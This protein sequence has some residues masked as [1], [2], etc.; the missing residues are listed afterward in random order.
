MGTIVRELRHCDAHDE[1]TS[2]CADCRTLAARDLEEHMGRRPGTLETADA[3][4]VQAIG[5]TFPGRTASKIA[6]GHPVFF[7]GEIIS[8]G[9]R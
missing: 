6:C 5:G 3:L 2:G 7:R 1:V 8:E 4:V 9:G